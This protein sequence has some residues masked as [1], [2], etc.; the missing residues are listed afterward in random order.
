MSVAIIGGLD[1]L[2]KYYEKTGDNM[3]F[4]IRCFFQRIPDIR[5]RLN[6]VKGII[7]FTGTI[8][9][10][11]VTEVLRAAKHLNIP[12]ERSHSSGPDLEILQTNVS[13]QKRL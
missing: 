11:L 5:K 3:G 1:R 4:D 6:S 12:V 9:H 7:I 2:K 13:L 8:S 10:P